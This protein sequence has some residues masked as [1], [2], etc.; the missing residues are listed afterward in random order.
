MAKTA[1]E[2][3][4]GLQY[5]QGMKRSKIPAIGEGEGKITHTLSPCSSQSFHR[6]IQDDA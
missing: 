4:F 6:V 2:H 5:N 3:E 1:L